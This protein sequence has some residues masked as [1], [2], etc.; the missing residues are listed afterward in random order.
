MM[1][2]PNFDTFPPVINSKC[3]LTYNQVQKLIE[4]KEGHKI[5]EDISVK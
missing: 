3:R 4:N 5:P 1:E 2:T